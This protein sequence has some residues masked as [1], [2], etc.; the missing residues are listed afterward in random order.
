MLQK[1]S[2]EFFLPV[3][4]V[5]IFF[6]FQTCPPIPN[7]ELLSLL[8][9]RTATEQRISQF[10][11]NLCKRFVNKPGFSD[12]ILQTAVRIFKDTDLF[13]GPNLRPNTA[14]KRH[15]PRTAVLKVVYSFCQCDDHFITMLEKNF[16]F[17]LP[18]F[19]LITGANEELNQLCLYIVMSCYCAFEK[20]YINY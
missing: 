10:S 13:A 19:N 6:N 9:Y 14:Q 15:N 4:T 20:S 1:K 3:P 16:S 11:I 18:F 2:L 7:I 17:D 5:F 8:V 12:K